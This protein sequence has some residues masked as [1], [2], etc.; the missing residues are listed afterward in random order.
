V[1]RVHCIDCGTGVVVDPSGFC[2]DGHRV[3]ETGARIE[4]AIGVAVPYPD[5]PEPWVATVEERPD[6]EPNPAQPRAARPPTAPDAKPFVTSAPPTS[7]FPSGTRAPEATAPGAR[8]PDVPEG[9]VPQ[10]PF[11][12]TPPPGTP[13]AP[14]PATTTPAAAAAPPAA[15]SSPVPGS[16]DTGGGDA[17]DLHAEL[18]SLADLDAAAEA[19]PPHVSVSSP[20]PEGTQGPGAPDAAVPDV[21]S[22][23]HRDGLAELRAL[24]A[25]VHA[26]TD[27]SG[28]S[29]VAPAV[30]H[31]A[32]GVVHQLPAAGGDGTDRPER[33]QLAQVE[34]LFSPR[35][36]STE[37]GD[38]S[39]PGP[40]SAAESHPAH[41]A[42]QR[43]PWS[44]GGAGEHAPSTPAPAPAPAP[45]AGANGVA[46]G[47]PS[48]P[49]PSVP[50]PGMFAPGTPGSAGAG[51]ASDDDPIDLGNFT[52]RGRRVG[53]RV[54][55]KRRRRGR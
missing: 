40:S 23:E 37:A 41:G 53:S 16:T 15:T 4:A 34:H 10:T 32:D 30:P 22:G 47:A 9:P 51:E 42:F 7:V 20:D 48:S 43:S 3:G 28:R 45:N 1:S 52:A 24:E 35:P 39:R 55:A 50:P 44:A 46:A 8:A 31:D 33:E 5:E 29:E 25:A 17:R 49:P 13:A 2:P 26:L 27:G 12:A 14:P 18:H 54:E 6:S 38:V 19:A 36:R 21:P 11:P